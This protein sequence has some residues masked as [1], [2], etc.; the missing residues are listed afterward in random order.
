MFKFNFLNTL[1]A[2]VLSIA[3]VL[4]TSYGADR[5]TLSERKAGSGQLVVRS[6]S[7]DRDDDTRSVISAG[8]T[9]TI[10]P[11]ITFE[12]REITA[13][14]TFDDLVEYVTYL[15]GKVGEYRRASRQTQSEIKRYLVENVSLL[16]PITGIEY[17]G[18]SRRDTLD[19]SIARLLDLHRQQ[20]ALKEAAERT[21]AAAEKAKG[22]A[23]SALA[24]VK[25]EK[26]EAEKSAAR[27]RIVAGVTTGAGVIAVAVILGNLGRIAAFLARLS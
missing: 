9:A 6:G 23:E 12:T 25:T 5:E 20:Q 1:S 18:G 17:R 2:G 7:S 3:A 13:S 26:G 24:V 19:R 22:D 27:W 21:A 8:S 15:L 4:S 11:A 10:S 16:R 14:T